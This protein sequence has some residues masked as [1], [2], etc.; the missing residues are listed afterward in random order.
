MS[1]NQLANRCYK[2]S[3]QNGFWDDFQLCEL[4]DDEKSAN[5]IIGTKLALISSEVSE[6][7]DEMRSDH[8]MQ[9]F[10]NELADIIIRTLDLAKGLDIDIETIVSN[11]M[12]KNE[13]RPR[14]HGKL[15]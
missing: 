1:L 3:K 12:D 4:N 7:L 10:A 11:K 6:A 13:A 9:E 2:I 15:F 8:T 5:Y 14:L